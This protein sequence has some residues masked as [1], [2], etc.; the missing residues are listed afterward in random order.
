MARELDI[1]HIVVPP[2]AGNFS[3]W[4]L[5]GSDLIRSSSQT[6][7]FPLTDEGLRN[8]NTAIS[9]MFEHLE[10]RDADRRFLEGGQRELSVG[11]R[12]AGQEHSLNIPVPL[13]NGATTWTASDFSHAFRESYKRTFGITLDN[14]VEVIVL[15]TAIRKP[16]PRK[17]VPS[18]SPPFEAPPP[19]KMQVHSFALG[20]AVSAEALF[21]NSLVPGIRH[22]GPAIIYEDTT[23]T[24]VDADFSYGVD[25]NACLMLNREPKK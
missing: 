15:R 16:L 2:F 24:Y 8:M 22:S 11:L 9:A 3:A 6:Q 10:G 13:A 23:T 18:S 12:F 21:R 20:R 5:V 19:V 25:A 1:H 17:Y 4:G 14:P 7:L